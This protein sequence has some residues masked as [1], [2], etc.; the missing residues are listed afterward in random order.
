MPFEVTVPDEEQ[1]RRLPEKLHAER[2][3]ILTWL[4]DGCRAWQQHGLSDPLEVRM[5]T[6]DYRAAQDVIAQFID[7]TC[8]RGPDLTCRAGDLYAAYRTWA[9]QGGERPL[10][11]RT[12]GERMIEREGIER[13]RLSDGNHYRWLAIGSTLGAHP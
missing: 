2:D 13:F 11:V 3:G 8:S 12:F 10:S 4:V 6:D 9:E 7:A 1:D 5:A